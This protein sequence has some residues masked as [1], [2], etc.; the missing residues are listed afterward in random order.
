MSLYYSM[1]AQG[2]GRIPRRS[3]PC[4]FSP[5][6]SHHSPP[7]T[8]HPRRFEDF[9]LR[10][11]ASATFRKNLPGTAVIDDSTPMPRGLPQ[12]SDL[13]CEVG[14][15]S[16]LKLDWAQSSFFLGTKFGGCDRENA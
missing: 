15:V 2:Y 12:G 8:I 9:C 4:A 3:V 5:N 10:T 11:D 6:G 13:F 7:R 14:R 1:C 16:K